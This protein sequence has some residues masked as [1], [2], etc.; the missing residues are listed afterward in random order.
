MISMDGGYYPSDYYPKVE[1]ETIEDNKRDV[2]SVIKQQIKQFD[3]LVTIV[4]V[5]T[6]MVLPRFRG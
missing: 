3:M 1:E 6:V 2:V 5:G 4:A